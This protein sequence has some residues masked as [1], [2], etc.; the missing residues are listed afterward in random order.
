NIQ[1]LPT[2]YEIRISKDGYVARSGKVDIMVAMNA[3]TYARDVRDVAPGGYLIYDST[4][5]RPALLKRDDVTVLG[6][7]L[8]RLCNENFKGVRTRILMKNICYA[9][10]LAALLDLDVARI[11][12]LLAE[13]Y[14]KKPALVESNMQ[15][16]QLG[17]DYAKA[18]FTCPLPLRIE[19]MDKTG[20]HLMIDGNTAAALGCVYAGATVAAW[21]PITP[22]TSLMDAF[23]NFADKTRID[24]ETGR[25]NFAFIQAED[26]LAAIGMVLGAN[27]NGARSFTATS[28]PGV[29]LMSEF[30]GLAYYAEVPAV[31]FDV[32]R[33]G[34]STGMPTRT[35][36]CDL[37]SAA[38]AS[39][40]DTKHICLYPANPEE[41]FYMAVQAFDLAERLQTPVL[42]MLDLDIGMNDWMC[43]D[44][45]W[46][47]NYR[48]DRGKVLGKAELEK[49]EK[50]Y[51]YLDKDEDGIPYRTFPGVHPKGA[52]FT[53]GSGHTQFGTYTEDSAEY[54]L[55]LDRLLR[56]LAT[57]KRHVPR[58][59]VEGDGKAKAAIVSIGSCDG[60]VREAL[61]VIAARG[62]HLDYMRVRGFPFSE[63]VEKFLA[64]HE[65]IYVVEQNRDAQFKSLLTL[66]TRV[67]KAKLRS[68]LHYS[69]LPASS[70]FIVDGVLGDL[71]EDRRAVSGVVS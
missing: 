17:Y 39:H 8:A 1:G 32:Q 27:W 4:W 53:R 31:L 52:Y 19:K 54:Q 40:G 35:Q 37:I 14:A 22:S 59:V 21:Y 55:V 70:K 20:G 48:P 18:N 29:S 45:V 16:I 50:F 5:P 65:I 6:V 28:G 11:R 71:L 30:L 57:A 38:Y 68:L 67:D 13:T 36:Q 44:L 15:A 61:D 23:K 24:P 60:A 9:G 7:P 62:V 3:E 43:R 56:K 69:G 46:D 66:E 25:A 42:V 41:C 26:E 49:I 63:E 2:W 47:D 58:P 34:P 51:R 33:V 10:V 12:E 64:D